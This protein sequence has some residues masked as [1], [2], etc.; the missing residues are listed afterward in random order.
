MIDRLVKQAMGC[1]S[2]AASFMLEKVFSA[3]QLV[4]YYTDVVSQEAE[5]TLNKV[6]EKQIYNQIVR[7]FT[8]S[9]KPDYNSLEEIQEGLAPLGYPEFWEFAN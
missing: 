1:L 9:K 2:S 7:G 3:S 8:R 6:A 5:Q 4:Q